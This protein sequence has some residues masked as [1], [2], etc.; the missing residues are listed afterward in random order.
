MALDQG[1]QLEV[2][3]GVYVPW[4]SDKRPFLQ[5]T[6]RIAELRESYAKGSA[7][8]RVAKEVGNSLYGK[9][10][11]GVA[12]MRGDRGS[13]A[14]DRR[15][16]FNARE[17]KMEDLDPSKITQ[18][19]LAAFI[20]GLVRAVLSEMLARLPR[21]T[22]VLTA[23]TDGFWSDAQPA[24]LDNTGP[25]VSL[26]SKLREM[27]TGDPIPIEVKDE[28]AVAIVMK[29]RGA[30][31]TKPFDLAEPG[32]PIL[33]RA[34]TRLEKKFDDPWN[35]CRELE[36]L[37]R[38]RHFD[39]KLT[40]RRMIN[41]RLQ[42]LTELDLVDNEQ[43]VRVNLDYDLKRR[44][45]EVTDVNGVI[46]FRTEA[47]QTI[48]EF[49][50]HR[51]AFENWRPKKRRVLRTAQDW[52]DFLQYKHDTVMKAD[53]G[54]RTN[55]RPPIVQLFLNSSRGRLQQRAGPQKSQR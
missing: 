49:N 26:F 40:Q 41:L 9:V 18:P 51:N 31:A 20:T 44:P 43:E 24:Q 29:T 12:N 46:C 32:K 55:K 37:Y 53:A 35:E 36:A 23:T 10:A 14:G 50:E 8:E 16:Q 47:W 22:N 52:H 2:Q 5:F 28:A 15:R 17:G 19:L 38:D 34:G 1:A 13:C 33:A 11:Q 3:A 42:W 27:A 45:I 6:H 7:L 54:V 25:L 48:E 21:H 4:A 39:L 30:F